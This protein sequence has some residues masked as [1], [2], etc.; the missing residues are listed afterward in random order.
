MYHIF[1]END[2]KQIKKMSID[3]SYHRLQC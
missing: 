1:H 2:V 3:R